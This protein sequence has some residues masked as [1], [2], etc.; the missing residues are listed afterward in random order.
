MKMAKATLVI[1]EKKKTVTITMPI[2]DNLSKTQKSIVLCTTHGNVPWPAEYK[3]ESV[4]CGV[5]CYIKNRKYVK[6][7]K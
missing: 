6:P 1:D 3:G 4:V 2:D 7:P 5:N